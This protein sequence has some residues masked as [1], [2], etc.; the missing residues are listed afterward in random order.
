M[1][2][3]LNQILIAIA[4]V[5]VVVNLGIVGVFVM[6]RSGGTSGS[7][8][9]GNG[10]APNAVLPESPA[11]YALLFSNPVSSINAEVI[12]VTGDQMR[13]VYLPFDPVPVD[14][15]LEDEQ[16]AG[17]PEPVEFTVMIS[18][19]T[20]V[21]AEQANLPDFLTD[22]SDQQV[23]QVG[24]DTIEIDPLAGAQIAPSDITPGS[25]ILIQSDTDL[26]TLTEPQFMAQ[27]IRVFP[28]AN[29][30]DGEIVSVQADQISVRGFVVDPVTF[31]DPSASD[32]YVITVGSST[33]IVEI[34]DPASGEAEPRQI[35]LSDLAQGELVTVY[36][37]PAAGLNPVRAVGIMS[38][39]IAT[40]PPIAEPEAV[41]EPVG[42]AGLDPAIQGDEPT[43]GGDDPSAAGAGD[44]PIDVEVQSIELG[45][46]I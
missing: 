44:E 24:Q 18:D 40:P 25:R 45:A 46:G 5:V 1:K 33:Q 8:A 34:P 21:F 3:S 14:P 43:L 31:G 7:G 26:R 2:W 9:A 36:F 12:S 37:D 32:Q 42:D 29:I 39:E 10:V 23:Q 30:L 27:E 13:V 4:V 41:E 28:E 38:N 35:D 6:N 19:Q 15:L 17:P 16:Q 11:P 22:E 20:V